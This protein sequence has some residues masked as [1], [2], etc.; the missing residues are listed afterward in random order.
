MLVEPDSGDDGLDSESVLDPDD[1]S[2]SGLDAALFGYRAVAH[3]LQSFHPPFSQAVALYQIFTENVAPIIRIFHMPTLDRVYWDAMASSDPLDKNTEALLLAIYYSAIISIGEDECQRVLRL[4]RSRAEARYRFAVEQSLARARLLQTRSLT[5]LQAA[6]VFITALRTEDDTRAAW[7]LTALVYHLAQALGVHRD[8]TLFGL[9]PFDTEMRRRLWWHICFLDNR[10]SE[11]HGHEPIVTPYAF[12]AKPPLN[13]N[14]ADLTPEMAEFP[15]ERVGWTDMTFCVARTEASRTQW[16]IGR[17]PPG[18]LKTPGSKTETGIS[19]EDGEAMVRDLEQRLEEKYLRHCDPTVPFQLLTVLPAKSIIKRYNIMLHYPLGR[20]G[21][22]SGGVAVEVRDR[23][24]RDSIEMMALT[25]RVLTNPA[26]ARWHW[27]GKT[28]V[29]WHAVAFMLSELCS[30]PPSADCDRAWEEVQTTCNLDGQK[31]QSRRGN[32]W[33]P[34]RRMMAKARYVREMQATDPR[35]R[36]RRDVPSWVTSSSMS[37]QNMAPEYPTPPTDT[38]AT[39]LHNSEWKCNLFPSQFGI[40][41]MDTF[42]GILPDNTSGESSYP[43][44]DA[45]DTSSTSGFGLWLD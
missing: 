41:S 21:G 29:P 33:R 28:W 32:M 2:A 1:A 42:L 38:P 14:D 11:Y 19:V 37:T 26:L 44:I 20:K 3:S 25:N 22:S 30:R 13:V 15:A 17:T 24:F 45:E 7:S 43:S 27:H 39:S 34:I 23:L 8:G 4:P 40:D 35:G 36:G 31:A 5:L 6:V 16:K 10:S 12:D 9:A 18:R